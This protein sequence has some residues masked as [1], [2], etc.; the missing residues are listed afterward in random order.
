MSVSRADK[1]TSQGF[2]DHLLLLVFRY[3]TLITFEDLNFLCLYESVIIFSI[4]YM[5]VL[6][7]PSKIKLTDKTIK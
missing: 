4:I 7:K 1:V 6:L 3:I 2:L 5:F